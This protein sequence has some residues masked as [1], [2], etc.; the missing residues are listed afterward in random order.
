MAVGLKVS[1]SDCGACKGDHAD[2]ELYPPP[3]PSDLIVLGGVT[4]TETPWFICPVF[5]IAVP[6][7]TKGLE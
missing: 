4:L 1:V 2:I 7:A 3:P 6:A 5:N